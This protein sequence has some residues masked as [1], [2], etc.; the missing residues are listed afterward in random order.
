MADWIGSGG[1]GI[2][3]EKEQGLEGMLVQLGHVLV[4]VSERYA[5]GAVHK[6]L[7]KYRSKKKAYI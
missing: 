2:Y 7:K 5:S 3:R 6:Q 1:V 4:Q